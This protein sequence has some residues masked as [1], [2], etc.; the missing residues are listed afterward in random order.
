[1][2]SDT[3]TALEFKPLTDTVGAEIIGLN[4]ERLSDSDRRALYEA[5]IEYHV[6]VMRATPMSEEVEMEFAQVFG[7]IRMGKDPSG[8]VSPLARHPEIMVISNIR[9]DGVL[10]GALPDGEMDWHFDG[11]Y[12]DKPYVGAILHG[13]ELP[14]AGGE[15]RF[16]SMVAVYES[17]PEDLRSRLD[18]LTALHIYDYTSTSR[19]DK[20]RDASSPRSVHPLVRVH[21]KS[22]KKALYLSR[23]MTDKIVELSQE[24][25]DELL[26]ILF[27]NV[28]VYP[29]FYEHAWNVGDSVIWDNRAVAHSRTD[30]DSSERRLL[31]RVTIVS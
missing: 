19:A 16:K 30:F 11:L 17:L 22:G 7:A 26:D 21:E 29:S 20:K 3:T 2:H 13:I 9:A 8:F 23:L 10:Q 14:R 1:M 31:K 5:W 4:P 24:E 18:G 28:D 15:T 25:S 27:D 12:F 6:L